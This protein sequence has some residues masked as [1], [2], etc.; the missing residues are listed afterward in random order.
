ML[1]VNIEA[2]DGVTVYQ[3]NDESVIADPDEFWGRISDSSLI[4]AKGTQLTVDPGPPEVVT[5][6]AEE[7]EIQVE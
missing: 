1:G 4:K 7:I 6:T 5:L 2:T 3:N